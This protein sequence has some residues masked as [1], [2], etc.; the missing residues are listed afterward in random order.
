MKK[1][2]WT[3]MPWQLLRVSLVNMSLR[4]MKILENSQS[5][6]AFAT[7]C[8]PNPA[9]KERPNPLMARMWCSSVYLLRIE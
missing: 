6:E 2:N 1:H 5:N 4:H 8:K 9:I 3:K 7:P